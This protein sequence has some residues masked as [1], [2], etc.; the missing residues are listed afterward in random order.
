MSLSSITPNA[1]R[2]LSATT[3]GV[4]PDRAIC[5]TLATTSLGIADPLLSTYFV[6]A[7]AAPLRISND[8]LKTAKALPKDITHDYPTALKNWDHGKMDG[9]DLLKESILPGTNRYFRLTYMTYHEG[10]PLLWEFRFYVKPD[11]K[12]KLTYVSW[13]DKNPF[14]YLTSPEMLIDQWYS[15]PKF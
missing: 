14:E 6:I 4:P 1:P 15:S 12:P 7:S 11:G 8:F 9:F 13:N 10:A 2:I 3:N 5:S